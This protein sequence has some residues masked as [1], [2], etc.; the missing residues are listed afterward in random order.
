MLLTLVGLCL[1]SGGT[2]AGAKLLRRLELIPET[3]TAASLTASAMLQWAV[4]F[5]VLAYVVV[6]ERKPLASIGVPPLPEG[7]LSHPVLLAEATVNVVVPGVVWLVVVFPFA[8]GV[9]WLLKRLGL[10]ALHEVNLLLLAQPTHRK[11]FYAVTAGV[12]EEILFRG[13]LVERTL[14]LTGSV[15]I[16][17]GLSV[18]VFALNHIPGR[19]WR[20]VL[21]ILAPG[22][23]FVFV[24]LA[25]QNVLVVAATHVAYDLLLLLK[26]TPGDVLD[27]AEDHDGIDAPD[28]DDR[29]LATIE[30]S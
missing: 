25:T 17:A 20:A 2:V 15:G 13:Y 1:V 19:D 8:V 12:T 30:E 4:A 11:V 16:A 21:P 18:G 10:V 3:G 22:A 9:A 26:A 24:Y 5:V 6:V 28:I 29:R 23:G 27:A 14:A 7:V